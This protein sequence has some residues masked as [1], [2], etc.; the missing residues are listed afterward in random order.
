MQISARHF[1]AHTAQ[2]QPP[3]GYAVIVERECLGLGCAWEK[4]D[5]RAAST[6]TGRH[7]P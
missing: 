1:E 5:F 3:L 2:I 7:G 6:P 4:A